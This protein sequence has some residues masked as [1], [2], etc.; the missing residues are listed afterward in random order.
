MINRSIFR[1]NKNVQCD[2]EAK[3]V[4]VR[5]ISQGEIES[6]DDDSG[7]MRGDKENLSPR[8]KSKRSNVS[9]EKICKV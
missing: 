1:S 6:I 5:V 9:V 7:E 8:G 2:N 4:Q 3:K